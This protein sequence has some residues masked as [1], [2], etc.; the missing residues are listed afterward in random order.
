MKNV[1][2]GKV[3]VECGN[4]KHDGCQEYSSEGGDSSTAGSF[5]QASLDS[6]TIE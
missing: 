1:R 4:Y 3:I 5:T 6:I 2:N